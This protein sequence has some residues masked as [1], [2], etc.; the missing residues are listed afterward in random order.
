MFCCLIPIYSCI[1]SWWNEASWR[2]EHFHILNCGYWRL[3]RFL[4]CVLPC[5]ISNCFYVALVFWHITVK[6]TQNTCAVSWNGEK[7]FVLIVWMSSF[8]VLICLHFL[9]LM[10]EKYIIKKCCFISKVTFHT[11]IYFVS[12]WNCLRLL[13]RLI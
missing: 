5:I 6:W 2:A 8:V 11:W 9:I 3:D 13:V 10:G 4:L 7:L 12:F 1:T